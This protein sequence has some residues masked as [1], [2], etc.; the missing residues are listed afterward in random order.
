MWIKENKK[1]VFL[2]FIMILACFYVFWA[3]PRSFHEVISFGKI[4]SIGIEYRNYSGKSSL[5]KYY[6][7]NDIHEIAKVNEILNRYQYSKKLIQP[8]SVNS[9]AGD[10]IFID[11][12][13]LGTGKSQQCSFVYASDAVQEVN[14]SEKNSAE[15]HVGFFNK[16]ADALF[17]EIYSYTRTLPS[18]TNLKDDFS[19]AIFEVNQYCT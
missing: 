3:Y 14:L 11:I 6:I 12:Y 5:E 19:K 17:Q 4:R 1:A 15:Y 18:K 13:F 10:S 7:I 9:N 2:A 8:S 16:D